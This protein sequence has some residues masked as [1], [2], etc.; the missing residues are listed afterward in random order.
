MPALYH[1]D[2]EPAG[3]ALADFTGKK[4]MTWPQ[5]CDGKGWNSAVSKL[6]GIKSI[7]RMMLVNG[8]TGIILS[9]DAI[10]GENLAPAIEKALAAVS[11]KAPAIAPAAPAAAPGHARKSGD[12]APIKRRM[13]RACECR[14]TSK[15]TRRASCRYRLRQSNL[16]EPSAH[17]GSS[18]TMRLTRSG[19]ILSLA[20]SL[21]TVAAGIPPEI[22]HGVGIH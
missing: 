7:P 12:P 8:S 21:I 19:Q 20:A 3:A 17:S 6:Y 10:R 4:N 9:D 2:K 14:S 13:P 22:H 11:G 16:R 15:A 18:R 5:V 1:V